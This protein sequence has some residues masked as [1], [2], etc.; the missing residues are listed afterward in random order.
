M[1]KTLR[2]SR[3]RGSSDSEPVKDDYVGGHHL[4]ENGTT[5]WCTKCGCNAR[6]NISGLHRK[7]AG[8]PT[9][10]TNAY[11][12]DLLADNIRPQSNRRLRAQLSEEQSNT[13]QVTEERLPNRLRI[14]GGGG[15]TEVRHDVSA[16]ANVQSFVQ[17]SQI[18]SPG[19]SSILFQDSSRVGPSHFGYSWNYPFSDASEP[20][21][22]LKR[23]R[24]PSRMSLVERSLAGIR[25]VEEHVLCRRMNGEVT[26]IS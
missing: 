20:C 18:P 6:I 17:Q 7:C 5:V 23:K 8:R 22:D 3:P 11:R 19:F 10:R 12:L 15:A 1:A 21:P 14:R 4:V 24:S 9:S 13:R 2:I 26:V 16:D 25:T